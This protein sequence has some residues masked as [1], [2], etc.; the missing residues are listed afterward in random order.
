MGASLKTPYDIFG[1]PPNADIH[2]LRGAFRE[3]I[4]ALKKG[5]I[6]DTD[7]RRICRAYE[8]LSDENSRRYF[9]EHQKWISKLPIASYTL[10]QLAAEPALINNLKA[11]LTKATLREINEQHPSTGHTILYCAARAGNLPAVLY[12]IRKGAEPDLSQRT[13]STALHVSAFYQHPEVVRCLL[14]NGAD[15]RIKN[16]YNSTAE[17]EV[18]TED[19]KQIFTEMKQTPFV[20]A[21]A[22]QLSWFKN[23]ISQLNQHIDEQYSVQRQTLLHCASKKGYLTLVHWLVEERSSNLD[24]VDVNLNSALHLAAYGGYP[25]VV[26][27]LLDR[28]SNPL[29]INKWNMTA[30]GEGERHGM[31]ICRVFQ[32]IRERNMFT[33]AKNDVT[34][35]FQYHFGNNSPNAVDSSGASLLYIA[36]RYGRTS[37]AKWLLDHGANINIKLEQDTQSTPLHGA[38]Y[39]CHISTVELL[40]A[41]GADVNITNTHGATVFDEAKCDTVRNILNQYRGNLKTDKFMAVHVY[42]EKIDRNGN[43]EPIAKIHLRSDAK[44]ND[45]LEAL[46][47]IIRDQTGYFSIAKRPLLFETDNTTVLTAVC[48]ARYARSNFVEIPLRLTFSTGKPSVNRYD[49]SR[50][51][52]TFDSTAFENRFESYSQSSTLEVESS[53]DKEQIYNIGDLS[54]C[55]AADSSDSDVSIDIKYIKYSNF[56]CHSLPGG[57]CLFKITY[58]SRTILKQPPTVS[59][60]NEP[61]AR[62]YTLAS[63]SPFWLTYETSQK[64]LPIVGGIHA[65][66]RHVDIIPKVLSLPADMLLATMMEL[67]LLRRNDPVR[68]NYLKLR[69]HNVDKF[70]FVVYH[71]TRIEA[72]RSII[73][74]GLVAPNT[75]VSNGTRVK[76]PAHHIPL[77]TNV[78]SIS[79]FAGAIFASP[80]IHYSS[81]PIYATSFEYEGKRLLPVL[82]CSV[83][84]GSYTTHESTVS[85][86]TAHPTD[87]I[88]TIEWRIN[89]PA[90]I[91]INGILFVLRNFRQH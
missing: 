78:N 90:D 19:I 84:N 52:L 46:P 7:Y 25:C 63:P 5:D 12:L 10:Q 86:Y 56:K 21:A 3:H 42:S 79:N 17:E 28:G 24:I 83:K 4:H 8:C 68:C 72:I 77:Y 47:E 60:L 9:D 55:I 32:E 6:S 81:H 13:K 22:N 65:F 53:R 75:L 34:W 58:E 82:E 16:A 70:P 66:V 80:S 54:F 59:F 87:D 89:N 41:Y 2:Q 51:D 61:N 48:C 74:D 15:Y 18:Y 35:W 27:Y 91:E 62:L 37:V 71:G 50:M 85:A 45:L 44:Q 67:P 38:A 23:N 43:D 40:L 14:E 36:C 31:K 1:V 20:Q 33:M 64:R 30:E 11:R 69:V 76:P 49:R 88:N 57:L 39:Y 26:E 29:L 73:V